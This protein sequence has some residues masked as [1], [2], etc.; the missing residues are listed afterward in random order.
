M[1]FFAV[2]APLALCGL[3]FMASAHAGSDYINVEQGWTTAD[4][5]FWYTASQGSRLVP[6]SWL[7]ALEQADSDKPF[8]AP[9]Y[10]ASLRYLPGE[11]ASDLPVGFAIDDEDDS[12]LTFT[13]L[14]WKTGQSSR[15][16]WFGPTCSMCH[17]NEMTYNGK[18][19]RIEG[20]PTL[21]DFQSFITGLDKALVQTLNDEQKFARF[22]AKVLAGTTAG[23]D[24]A[25]LHDA[26]GKLVAWE[27]TAAKANET[28]LRYGF[29]R[30]DAIGYTYN[31]LAMI[32][33]VPPPLTQIYHPSDAPVSYPHM[34]NTHQLSAVQWDGVAP[35]GPVVGG[36]DIGALARNTGEAVAVYSDVAI[37][38]YL[39]SLARP[40]YKSSVNIGNLDKIERLIQKLSPPAWPA[41]FPPI[42][43][44]K[45]AAGEKIFTALC[46][47]CHTRLDHNDLT[48]HVAVT[49]TLLSGAERIGTDPWMACNAYANGSRTGLMIGTPKGYFATPPFQKLTLLGPEAP[50]L[51]MFATTVVGVIVGGFG[52]DRQLIDETKEKLAQEV[53]DRKGGLPKPPDLKIDLNNV[54]PEIA[55]STIDPDKAAQL[56][57][58]LT[59]SNPLLGYKSGPLNGIWATAPY[60]HN[61]SVPTLYDLLLPPGERP[62]SF[63][64]GTREFDPV[65]V[66]YKTEKSP[67]NSFLFRVEDE[68]GQ[69]I[70]GNLNTGHDYGNA[71]LTPADREALVEYMKSL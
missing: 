51:D 48:T 38:L 44:K 56:K 65:K 42:D 23:E 60:L 55:P 9:D 36:L 58:C 47:R 22:A 37:D 41:E 64:T 59:D 16:P 50:L 39:A 67:D 28:P 18:H 25:M 3:L 7:R 45:R 12:E 2:L 27:Q 19:L 6:L 26:L 63:Y 69:P 52:A 46:V 20:A 71:L 54:I 33:H 17:S 43:E 70:Q 34:W 29:G 40:G 68:K 13:K 61:G 21:A 8:V 35:N 11:G 31:K 5:T 1:R 14:R 4:K 57:R 15:E 66:G 30:L 10:I 62:K 24:K 32:A 53:F 49:N